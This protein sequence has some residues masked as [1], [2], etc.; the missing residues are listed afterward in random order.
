MSHLSFISAIR[1]DAGRL[2]ED[3]RGTG[4]HRTLSLVVLLACIA[5]RAT[6]QSPDLLPQRGVYTNGSYS[7]DKLE[8]INKQNGILTYSIPITTLPL[9]R[10]GMTVPVNLTY[11]S[12][13][14]DSY[15][16]GGY[17]QAQPVTFGAATGSAY[18]GWKFAGFSYGLYKIAGPISSCTTYIPPPFQFDVIMPD[19]AHHILKLYNEPDPYS[20]G[21]YWFDPDT[22]KN[23]CTGAAAPNPLMYYT[24][25]GSYIRVTVDNSNPP[26]SVRNIFLPD[27]TVVSGDWG[28]VGSPTIIQDRNGNRVTVST[29]NNTQ[30]TTLTDDEG[31]SIAVSSSTV[32]QRGA[33]GSTLTWTLGGWKAFPVSVGCTNAGQNGCGGYSGGGPAFLQIPSDSGTLQY[34]FG[35]D[36][37]SGELASVTLPNGAKTTYTYT[38]GPPT[39]AGLTSIYENFLVQTKTVTWT[40]RSDGTS[41]LRTEP[42]QYNYSNIWVGG[43]CQGYCTSIVAPDGG[44]TTTTFIGMGALKGTVTKETMPDGS[45]MEYLYQQNPAYFEAGQSAGGVDSANPFVRLAVHTVAH[46]GSPAFAGVEARMI[47]QNGNLTDDTSYDWIPYSQ[48]THD[49]NGHLNGFSGGTLLRDTANSYQAFTPN[50]TNGAGPPDNSNGYWNPAAPKLRGLMTRSVMTGAGT[51]AMTELSYD[52]YGNSIQERHWDSVKAASRP[53][54]L[55]AS[56]ASV[57]SRIFDGYGNLTQLTD[58]KGNV[59]R[60]SYDSSSLYPIQQVQAFGTQQAMTSQYAWDFT[61]GLLTSRTDSNNVPTTYGYDAQGRRTTMVEASGTPVARQTQ[62]TYDDQNRRVIVRRDQN[63]NG[64]GR[65]LS[66]TNYDELGRITL[67]QNLEDSTTQSA[68][69]PAAGIKVQTRYLYSGGGLYQAVSNPYRAASSSAASSEGTMGWTVTRYD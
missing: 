55:N 41:I 45:G 12:A 2:R 59:T 23:P 15:L 22:G 26:H 33:G 47:D 4:R 34:S 39:V 3:S 35:Y 38:S 67:T 60:F 27:G 25:D 65:L 16:Y 31:R 37:F 32:T 6:A 29:D 68:T 17:Q 66:I 48:L 11:S 49:S 58:P 8:A 36:S 50:A 24:T 64:D 13:L 19:G 69:D 10:G 5:I 18:G 30:I 21:T 46:A 57:T 40:D 1:S 43:S 51:G 61:T 54:Q 42:W 9:G 62:T 52:A 7:F 53:S 63:S 56:N 20:N 28:D 44:V 14:A